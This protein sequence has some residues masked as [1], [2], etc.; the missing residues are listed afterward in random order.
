MKE[1]NGS[2]LA[3]YIK[4]RQ[5]KMVRSLW[6]GYKLKPRL[7]I[8]QT[9]DDPVID[10]YVRLKKSYGADIGVEVDLYKIVQNE[11]EAKINELNNDESVQGIIIQL[12]LEDV[13]QTNDLVNS[14]DSIKDVDAL[15][16]NAK[17]DPATPIAIQWLLAG[18]NISLAGKKLLI[19]GAG[20]L[21]GLPLAKLW[22]A[23]G[24][25]VTVIDSDSANSE[26]VVQE[27]EV[28]ITATGQPGIITSSM[29]QSGAV[30]IDAGVAAE[31]GKTRGD[32]ADDVYERKDLTLTPKKGGVGPLTVAALFENVIKESRANLG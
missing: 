18:Y 21:V 1:L 15:G 26:S 31:H 6:S 20:R 16:D 10:T 32:L 22:Q 30:V 12:P 19:I 5:A 4:V 13:S 29:L 14:V 24:Y 7:A 25:N 9:K 27:S 23:S 11:A 3:S 8:I 2:E 17:F 28:V